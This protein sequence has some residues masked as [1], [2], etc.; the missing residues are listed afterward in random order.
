MFGV[1]YI[2]YKG[3]G[4]ILLQHIIKDLSSEDALTFQKKMAKGFFILGSIIIVMYIV[5][6]TDILDRDVFATIYI[7]LA[8][9]PII[10]LFNTRKNQDKEKS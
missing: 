1:G 7:L 6:L 2:Y 8:V 10:Y 4:Q 9:P 3:S 5:E